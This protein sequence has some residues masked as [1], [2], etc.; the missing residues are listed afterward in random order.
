MNPADYFAGHDPRNIPTP[1]A[2]E[3]D[4]K[5]RLRPLASLLYGPPPPEGARRLRRRMADLIVRRVSAAGAVTRDELLAA[6][7]ADEIERHWTPALRLAGVH[8][9]GET[10]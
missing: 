6:F 1:V 8:R 10:L 5:V 4:G 3:V 2:V 9:L 7:S